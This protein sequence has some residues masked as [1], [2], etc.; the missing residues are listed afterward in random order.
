MNKKEC[1]IIRDLLPSYVDNICSEASKE[2]IEA[3]ITECAECRRN[4]ELMK[5]TEISARMLEQI[6]LEAGKK[7]IR[8]NLRRSVWNLGLCLFVAFLISV[9]FALSKVQIPHAVLYIAFAFCIMMTGLTWGAQSKRRCW[10]KWDTIMT[11]VALL[12]TGYGTA[13]MW[14]GFYRVTAGEPVF[15]LTPD[16][17][18][19]FLYGQMVL[20]AAVCFL[21]YL[22]QVVR[23]V[24]QGRSNSLVLNLCLT[25]IFLM[26]TYCINMGYL[27]DLNTAM[28][29]LKKSTWT[30]LLIGGWCTIVYSSMDKWSTRTHS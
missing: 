27:T 2:W 18:G 20:A 30:V 14:Y 28:E 17:V 29:Q 13:M 1:D 26:M 12:A 25:G 10:D 24:K 22:I 19:S 15:G 7:V 9:V 21:L 3:H 5:H 6:Q 8:K 11:V 23:T 4:A 16:K